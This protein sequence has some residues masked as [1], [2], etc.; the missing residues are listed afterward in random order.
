MARK[1]RQGS[2]RSSHGGA[3][4]GAGPETAGAVQ[5]KRAHR[6]EARRRKELIHRRI[7]RRRLVRR[8]VVV[9]ALVGVVGVAGGYVF[10]RELESRRLNQAAGRLAAEAGCTDVVDMLDLGRTHLPADQTTTY[11]QR[12]ATSGLHALSPLRPD[13]HVYTDPVPE[14]SAVHNLEH[15]YVLIYYRAKGDAA[16]PSQVV[17][18]L[19]DLANGA[20]KVIMAPFLD[21]QQGTSLAFAAW[22]KLQQCPPT[23][24]SEQAVSLAEA[25]IDRFAS[26]GE[27]PEPSAP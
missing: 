22:N 2:P 5:D 20:T 18:P 8:A 19:A 27:A 7:R 14:T 1:K 4:P 17:G 9:G 15:G 11:G 25:F 26:G 13:P 3:S 23:V 6:E 10:S 24:N 21:L 16:L 12:P